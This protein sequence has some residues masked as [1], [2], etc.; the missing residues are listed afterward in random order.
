MQAAAFILDIANFLCFTGAANYYIT[1][2]NQSDDQNRN[3]GQFLKP[4]SQTE[5]QVYRSFKT[6]V[7]S[8]CSFKLVTQEWSIYNLGV[9]N[10][11]QK[12]V[13][14]NHS[15]LDPFLL[16]HI[17]QAKTNRTAHT[18]CNRLIREIALCRQCGGEVIRPECLNTTNS[19]LI[20]HTGVRNC[21]LANRPGR[22]GQGGGPFCFGKFCFLCGILSRSRLLADHR[23]VPQSL[24]T[25]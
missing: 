23:G 16:G 18:Q 4:W 9:T 22:S 13:F 12:N 24:K 25:Q 19:S 15:L 2:Q 17:T 7:I 11:K 3:L 8:P 10:L 1:Y 14:K 6:L 21:A 20:L 5:P